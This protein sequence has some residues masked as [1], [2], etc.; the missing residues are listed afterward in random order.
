MF[1]WEE[2]L[3]YAW[4]DGGGGGEEAG[5]GGG[6]DGVILYHCRRLFHELSQLTAW[7]GED[8]KQKQE[9]YRHGREKAG[10]TSR[11]KQDMTR[12]GRER[13]GFKTGKQEQGTA[14]RRQD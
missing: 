3:A 1:G 12:H 2:C 8:S 13:V 4:A 6:G 11:G 10:F 14:G 9:L 7:R 5:R